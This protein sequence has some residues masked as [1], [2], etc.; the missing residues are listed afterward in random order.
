MTVSQIPTIGH[1]VFR[2]LENLA[3]QYLQARQ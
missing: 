2:N 3:G 1:P